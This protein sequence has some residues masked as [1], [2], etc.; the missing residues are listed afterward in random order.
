MRCVRQQA[1]AIEGNEVE[2]ALHGQWN[3]LYKLLLNQ[4]L[5][6]PVENVCPVPDVL[7]EQ[8]EQKRLKK[9]DT[10]CE[11]ECGF[12]WHL[13]SGPGP[14]LRSLVSDTC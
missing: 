1:E 4:R 6:V 14:F 12:G 11:A 9:R 10:R 8:D 5:P 7:P 13:R 3:A 2:K